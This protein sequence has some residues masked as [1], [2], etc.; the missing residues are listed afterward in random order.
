MKKKDFSEAYEACD[1]KV[2]RYRQLHVIDFMKVYE[3]WNLG[4]SIGKSE[5]EWI[6]LK[7]LQPVT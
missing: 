2:R 7:L 1:L 6:F 3:Y 4:F 5:K